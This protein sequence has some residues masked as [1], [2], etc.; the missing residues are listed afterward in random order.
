MAIRKVSF[1]PGE[2]YHIYNRGNGKHKIFHDKKD[3]QRFLELLYICNQKSRIKVRSRDLNKSTFD[4]DRNTTIVS[5]GAYCLMPNHFHILLIENDEGGVSKFLQKLTTGYVMYYNQ[6]YKRSGSLFEGKFKSEHVGN[7]RYLKYLFSYIHLNP[8]KLTD[9]GWKN[10]GI[11]NI[12]KS[13]EYI[14]KYEYSSYIAPQ[15]IKSYIKILSPEAFPNYFL[16]REQQDKE[17][18]SWLEYRND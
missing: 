10:K 9:D 5:I 11:K 8:A 12:K 14:K 4:S 6:K 1:A 17:L 15:K 3:Y 2:C 16:N 13:L 18:V 7:D